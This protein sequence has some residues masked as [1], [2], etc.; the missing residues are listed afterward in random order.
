MPINNNFIA[1][2]LNQYADLLAIKGSNPFKIRAYRSAA[3]KIGNIPRQLSDM[4]KN[5]EN[6]QQFSGI[7]EGIAEKI[8]EIVETGQ[9]HQ[10]EEIKEEVPKE[11]LEVL[12]L[13]GLGPERVQDLYQKLNIQNMEDLD[14][15]LNSQEIRK[16]EGFGP[17]TEANIRN[18]IEKKKRLGDRLLYNKVE[19]YIRPLIEYMEDCEIIH[20]LSL[21]G[22]FRRRKETIGDIDLLA[23]G[24]EHKAIRNYYLAYEDIVD[25]ISKGETKSTVKLRGGLQVDLRIVDQENYGA[26]LV[27][28]TGSKD[29]NIRLRH[30]AREQGKKINE[31]GVY[32]E[33]TGESMGGA[34]EE[35]VYNAIDLPYI[36]PELREDR[37][38][39]E[40]AQ[41]NNLP[42]LI[43]QDDMKGDL[44]MHSNYSDGSSSIEDMAEAAQKL[45]YEYI[46]ITD[47]SQ[48]VTIANG[49]KE[50]EVLK[51]IEEIDDLNKQFDDFKI[52]KAIEVD[53]LEDGTLDYSKELLDKLDL[54]VCCVHYKFDLPHEKQME[55]IMRAMENPYFDIFG[56][57]TARRLN[58]REPIDIDMEKVIDKAI[59]EN[60][61]IELN[62]SPERLDINDI[63]CKRA[64][65]K[66]LKIV[67]STDAHG[68]N[69]LQNMK[70][71]INQARRGW[72]SPKDVLN[73][74]SLNDFLKHF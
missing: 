67:I 31:Y 7:G 41:Q 54:R 35:E 25:V 62:A 28:F 33:E 1:E 19:E 12:K 46:A 63:Y 37:G 8:A 53:I 70:Y 4:I 14:K 45:G 60:C 18:S 34:T 57:P 66:G 44:Q 24:G 29:H 65:E 74:R 9:L 39:I 50:E 26:A 58:D 11:L 38:E 69:Q 47:H 51:E 15:A 3:R 32:I 48:R 43:E 64:K 42:N 55:R 71:G 49:L 61:Y 5:D 16:L 68:P 17:K 22:S 36:I 56:H 73:T 13:D 2:T 40:A 52:L 20:Q 21:A 59:E 6:L 72:L 23:T 10:L 30:L 27:Y